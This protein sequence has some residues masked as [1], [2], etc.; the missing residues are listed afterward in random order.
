MGIIGVERMVLFS[1]TVNGG[2]WV[3]IKWRARDRRERGE[4]GV[5]ARVVGEE[6]TLVSAAVDD[7][8]MGL[9]LLRA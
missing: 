6:L 9:L 4:A 5:L 1:L 3:R 2:S 8:G 7:K